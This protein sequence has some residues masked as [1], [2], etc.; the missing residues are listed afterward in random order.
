MNNFQELTKRA[1]QIGELLAGR[2]WHLVTVESCT[3]GFVAQSLT[4]MAGSSAWFECGFVTYSN[5]SKQA[6]VGVPVRLIERYGAVSLEVAEAMVHGAIGRTG[7]QAGL[8][9]T[10]IA[11]PDGGSAEKPVGTVFIAWQV[12]GTAPVGQR[13][14]FAGDRAAVRHQ[15]VAAALEGLYE[16][17][18]AVA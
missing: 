4:A 17:A 8:A 13:F 11:G 14:S 3:G 9:I 2:G 15:S 10:G 12:P 5:R 1:G 6:L 18:A 16:R 7:A